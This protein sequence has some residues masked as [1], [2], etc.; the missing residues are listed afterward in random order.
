MWDDLIDAN[1]SYAATF[2]GAGV[3]GRAAR[4]LGLV[5]CMD[6]RIDPLAVLGLAVGD[7]KIIRNAGGRVTPDA[8][9]SLIL[10]A[11]FL[12]VERIVVMHHTRCALAG[13]SEAQTQEAL[14]GQGVDA[15]GWELLAMP[16]PDAALRA[17]VEAVRGCGLLPA[18]IPV[19]GWRYDVE[20]GRVARVVEAG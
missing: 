2:T 8:L 20:T 17:D 4:R 11:A 5:T 1:A 19:E 9:R 18:G 16:D 14:A 3:P 12:D 15:A 10:G 13:S 6:S 7:A